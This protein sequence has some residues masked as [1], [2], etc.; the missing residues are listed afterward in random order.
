MSRDDSEPELALGDVDANSYNRIFEQLVGQGSEAGTNLAGLVA[1]GL[2][3]VS[4]REWVSEFRQR[5]GR[6]PN[7]EELTEYTR[8]WTSTRLNGVRDAA[9]QALVGYADYVT[10]KARPEILRDALK[11]RF[12]QDIIKNMMASFFYTV[13]LILIAIVLAKAGIDLIGIFKSV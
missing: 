1:Y 9:S 11:G 6:S 7:G 2:Y 8:T 12:W 10:E 3:K 4:K 13:L 5:K